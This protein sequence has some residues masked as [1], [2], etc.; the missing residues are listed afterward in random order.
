[1]TNIK[2]ALDW[3]PN[4]NHV[5]FF[6]ARAKGFY[7][8]QGLEVELQ[9]PAADNYATTPAKRVELGLADLALCPTESLISYR[10]KSAPVP[11]LGIAALHREDLSAIA[12]LEASAISSPRE[13][14]GRSYA[15]YRARYEDGIIRQMVRNDGGTGD[16]SIVYP[17]KLGIWHRLVSGQADATWVFLNWEGVL[18]DQSEH[19]FRYFRLADFGIPY[20]YSPVVAGHAGRM[21][22]AP[23]VYRKFLAAT[24]RGHL[25][26]QEFPQEAADILRPH[27]AP[28]DHNIDLHDALTRTLPHLGTAATW[29]TFEPA[30][31]QKFLDWIHDHG[32]ETRRFTAGELVTNEYLG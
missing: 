28:Q 27:L 8:E 15:S 18:A 14:D 19:E 22:E 26:C 20:G 2:L 17:D 4:A 32:L 5:G 1:M 6:A 29:G 16:L 30:N 3:T 13:L 21:A 24:R 25:Y 11:L 7:R 23:E 12:V 10:T 31:V 9:D